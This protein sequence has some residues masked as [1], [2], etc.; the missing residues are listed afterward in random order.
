MGKDFNDKAHYLKTINISVHTQIL[1]ER[2]KNIKVKILILFY[3]H[4]FYLIIIFF[5][6]KHNN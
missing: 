2:I 3:F 1:N 5:K 4:N 6:N